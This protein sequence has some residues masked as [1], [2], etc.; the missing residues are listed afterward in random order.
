M[1]YQALYR[2]Y[3]P[4]KFSDV[5]DQESTLKIITN[6]I[7]ENK[8]SH[9]YLFS[10]P[11]GTGKTTI[12]KLLA[13]TVNCLDI[14]K[15]FSTCGKC[16]NCLD[17]ENNSSDII[18][19]DAASN[20]GVDEIRELKSK[21][22]LVPNKLK[23]KVYI[24]DE[25]HMLSI[26]AFN[27]LLK[28]LEEPPSHVI[29]ILATTE[30]Y[31]VPTT[32]VSRCQ[33]L[34]FTRIKTENI[35]K[36]LKEISKLEK[37]KIQDEAIHEIAVYSEGGMRDALG[38]L[39][40]LASYSLKEITKEDFL[41]ING[42]IS[43]SDIDKFIDEI[44][45]YKMTD[46]INTL[47]EFDNLGYDFS[48]LI[49]KI[50]QELRDLLVDCYINQTNKYKPTD[51][52]NLIICLN[53]SYNLLKEAANRKIILEVEL[54]T[55]MNRDKN[56]TEIKIENQENIHLSNSKKMAEK[57]LE[58]VKPIE[59]KGIDQVKSMEQTV[60]KSVEKTFES[61]ETAIS[62]EIPEAKDTKND[63][64]TQKDV[65]NEHKIPLIKYQLNEKIKRKRI[66]NTF[67]LASKML[68]NMAIDKWQNLVDYINNQET[69]EIAGL[70]KDCEIGV[71]SNT[72]IIF[73]TKYDSV[74]NKLYENFNKSLELITKIF[75]KEYKIVL[76]TDVEFKEEVQNYKEHMND[77]EYYNYQEEEEPMIKIL[78]SEVENKSKVCYSSLVAKAIDTF[79]EDYV[80]IE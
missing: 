26:S 2:K 44:L 36:R 68:K 78:E 11:R 39:D 48:K 75:E 80:E 61:S 34:N 51:L 77:K 64:E 37:I 50:M 33:C 23:Y 70:L 7:K 71:V 55:F 56:E 72:N 47:N 46:V 40:K 41:S 52:Y 73:V 8:I 13:K 66:D 14:Q 54:L 49:E 63:L 15:D 76:L 74:I 25:V 20:N 19:I 59:K 16:E 60:E 12:A 58:Q 53:E 17:I 27:A 4:S 79:G 28:T 18:E 21:I 38:M 57:V 43:K 5:V 24:I 62:Q 65:G 1:E 42:L 69:G 45:N 35:E 32:I 31:K 30:F 10:G 6:S 9:A 29:F 22:N 67:A 3:R